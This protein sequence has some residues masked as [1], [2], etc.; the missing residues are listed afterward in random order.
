[1]NP[2]Q[3]KLRIGIPGTLFSSYYLSY[4]RQIITI[5]GMEAVLADE[6]DKETAARG[7]R[8]LPHE[9]CIPVKVFIGHVLNLLEKKVD[10]I[11]L[12]RMITKGKTNFFCPKLIGLP[13]IVRFTTGLRAEQIFSPEVV[14][15]GLNLRITGFPK[16]SPNVLRRMKSAALQANEF[17]EG[18][19]AKCRD[20]RLTL[21]EATDVVKRGRPGE[22]LN[23]GLLGYAYS[24]YDP[25]ISKGI[26]NKL[27]QLGVAVTTWEMLD[28]GGIERILVGLKR[29][30]FWNF[31]RMLLGAG[32]CFINDPN[33]DGLIYATAF[34]CGPDSVA[35]KIL[36]IEANQKRKPLLQIN[37]DEHQEDGHLRTRLEA[38]VDM[39]ATLKE[40]RAI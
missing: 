33:I 34:G 30:L 24:L 10:Q 22:R 26:L 27:Y 9:F 28:P 8:R 20:Q 35:T 3:K 2:G 39:L 32:L 1:M 38:F 5:S 31:G 25:F 40:E 21:P 17:W 19:L 23:L 16:M 7:G 13:E 18:I 14:C 11:L 4:W 29:P 37:L 36:S 12:P 15:D 6:S